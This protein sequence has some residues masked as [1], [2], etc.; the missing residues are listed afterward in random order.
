M[1]KA[2]GAYGAE[3]LSEIAAAAVA[4]VFKIHRALRSTERSENTV[5]PASASAAADLSDV[6]HRALRLFAL[7]KVSGDVTREVGTSVP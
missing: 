6:L 5:A 7:C 4:T 2:T 1:G 3:I